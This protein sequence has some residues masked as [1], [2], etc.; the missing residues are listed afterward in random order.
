MKRMT[1]IFGITAMVAVIAVGFVAL[2][3]TGCSGSGGRT[4]T[5]A[6]KVEDWLAK[7]KG[8]ASVDDPISFS[9]KLNLQ[10]MASPE[11]NWQKLLTSINTA[12]LYVALD[13][14]G[15]TMPGPEFDTDGGTQ[16]GKNFIVSLVLP[17][18]TAS[19]N[20]F[21]FRHFRNLKTVKSKQIDFFIGNSGPAGGILFYDKGEYSDG[22][23]YLE[24]APANMVT[25]L[26]WVA[27]SYG[28]NWERFPDIA[29]TS[30][31]IGTGKRNTELILAV[32]PNAPAAKACADYRGGSFDNWFLPSR[33][34]FSLMY[35]NLRRNG[36]DDFGNNS[37]W[38]SSQIDNSSSF[39][40]D[41]RF[42]WGSY[43][44]SNIYSVRAIRA[45]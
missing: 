26:R 27:Q 15:S 40:L 2:S 36:I 17:D 34:E 3:L 10:N 24:A 44:K 23:R 19:V 28:Q 13:L 33:D 30:W 20:G 16:T 43:S 7:Q 42:D 45:F 41:Q 39:A 25:E 11:S 14:S 18:S 37:F 6:E 29:G 21:L 5:D 35:I 22:W 9:V 1:S 32:D 8:G 38:S 12:G 4:F 31:E